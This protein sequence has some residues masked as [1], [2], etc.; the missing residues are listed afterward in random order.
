MDTLKGRLTVR[1]GVAGGSEEVD[2]CRG[3]D[4]ARAKVFG[5]EE[6]PFRNSHASMASRVDWE[7]GTC[8]CQ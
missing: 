4:D 8:S 7:R 3:Y 2:E 5:N 1:K 6:C